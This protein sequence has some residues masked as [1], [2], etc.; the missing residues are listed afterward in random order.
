[1]NDNAAFSNLFPEGAALNNPEAY[2]AWVN[3]Y[4][5]LT[6]QDEAKIRERLIAIVPRPNFAVS[7]TAA[8]A[9]LYY[10]LATLASLDAQLYPDWTAHVAVNTRQEEALRQA[11]KRR[12][13]DT[14]RIFM[15]PEGK[16]LESAAAQGNFV[17]SVDPGDLLA[18]EA[19]YE[20][21]VASV[22][23]PSALLFYSDEDEVGIGGCRSTPR[24]KPAF[25]PGALSI[26]DSVGQLALFSSCLVKADTDRLAWAREAVASAGSSFPQRIIHIPAVLC[27]RRIPPQIPLRVASI[28][29]ALIPADGEK[30][31][32]LVTV[33]IPTRDKAELLDQCVEGLLQRTDYPSLEILVV[34]NNSQE[35]A[36]S[37]LFERWQTEARIKVLPFA[38]P[39]NW[40]EI[41][42]VAAAQAKGDVLLFLNNDID[43]IEPGWLHQMIE[44]VRQPDVGVVGARL[45]YPDGRL[46]HGGILLQPRGQAIHVER[47]AAR[48]HAGYLGRFVTPHDL[49]AVT[50][51]CMAI[52]R[53]VFQRVGGF[54]QQ[55][56]QV[57]W[58][59]IEMCLRIRHQ[60]YRIVW[61][62]HAT[63]WH[64]ESASLGNSASP[65]RRSRFLAER[66]VLLG[67]WPSAM[68]HDP[69]LNPNIAVSE[70]GFL[71]SK[72]RFPR[73]WNASSGEGAIP[74]SQSN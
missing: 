47:F 62:P 5:T 26:G 66:D 61:T 48:N 50:G 60:G 52:R 14:A 15:V 4:A 38:G 37:A 46:Q 39:F 19:F 17:A 63:L 13:L 30:T 23:Y 55:K 25:S 41:N 65:E 57:E 32:P 20:M 59:D 27:Q 73:S 31:L 45:L 68:E 3:E 70:T 51:A 54:E 72:P 10:L 24:F 40:G 36:T 74:S 44:L 12:G 64:L 53:D 35:E 33:I 2:A 42:N 28:P 9:D 11:L 58:S 71:L 18:P 21:A 43:V 29:P 7:L 49:S 56:L 69:Y 6:A 34:D 16:S 1:M 67:L 22:R 8:H